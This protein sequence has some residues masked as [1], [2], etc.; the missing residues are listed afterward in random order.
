M[1]DWNTLLKEVPLAVIILFGI[2]LIAKPLVNEVKGLREVLEINI[3]NHGA[4]EEQTK[5]CASVILE[6]RRFVELLAKM[7][8]PPE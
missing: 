2:Q 8:A 6:M 1:L 4:F 7:H 3:R 5:V